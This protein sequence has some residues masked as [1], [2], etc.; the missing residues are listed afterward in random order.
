LK[1]QIEK[2]NGI[3]SSGDVVGSLK[4]DAVKGFH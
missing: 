3:R 2:L 4:V 1:A